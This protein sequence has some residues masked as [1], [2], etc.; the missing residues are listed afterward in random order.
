MKTLFV[1]VNA[2]YVHTNLAVR[3]LSRYCA[4]TADCSFAEYTINEPVMQVLQ[5]LYMADAQM[6]GFSCYIW[7]ITYVLR[8]AED[9]KK[10]KP[11]CKIFL[12][13]PEVSFHAEELLK[14]HLFLDCVVCGEGEKSVKELLQSFP[15][16]RCVIQGEMFS[17]LA[18]MPFPYTAE[19][20]AQI[21]AGEKLVYYETTR[22]CPFHCSYCLSSV[23]EGV[24]A[25]SVARA[26]REI[27]QLVHAGAY[28]VKFVDRTFNANR[29][30]ALELWQ[31]C[32]ALE[33]ETKFHFEIGADL[34]DEESIA[35]L[36]TVA[37]EKFQFEIGVQTTNPETIAA[38]SRK[39]DLERLK[40]NVRALRE[41]GNIHLHLDLIAGLP[42]EDYATFGN[43]FHDI[44]A[45]RPHALQL[46]FLKLLRGSVLRRDAEKYG[47]VYSGAAPYEVFCTNDLSYRDII[48]LHAIEDV[49]ERYYNSGRFEHSLP[50]AERFF[51]S[52][53]SLYERLAVFWEN[54]GLVGQGVKRIKLYELLYV[55]LREETTGQDLT[56]FLQNMRRDFVQWHSSG[57]GTPEWFRLTEQK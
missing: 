34:L 12:G 7:N 35:F 41:A 53:F 30:R 4:E 22:G 20:L 16:E 15:S 48:C 14:E 21:V 26:K 55:F 42:F 1:A 44:Y 5:K 54:R 31:F 33:G 19:D 2:K 10:L 50:V 57:V 32:A 47:M 28:T 29:A 43:S 56:E 37:P 39:M 17:D 25:I 23:T 8:L 52:P 38:I 51:V 27:E 6:Y 36:R 9:L 46:G 3:Y 45:L 24:R 49:L 11:N 18:E 40:L 13:G